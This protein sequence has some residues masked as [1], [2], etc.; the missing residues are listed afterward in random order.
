M[1]HNIDLIIDAFDLQTGQPDSAQEIIRWP[2]V[3]YDPDKKEVGL[4]NKLL[5][6]LSPVTSM[7]PDVVPEVVS[8]FVKRA[9]PK[10]MRDWIKDY[11]FGS[12]IDIVEAFVSGRIG[13]KQYYKVMHR[14]DAQNFSL[15]PN[16]SA[17]AMFRLKFDGGYNVIPLSSA[18]EILPPLVN[19]VVDVQTHSK[20]L[21]SLTKCFP[22][23]GMHKLLEWLPAS[24]KITHTTADSRY[25]E[26]ISTVDVQ[27]VYLMLQR[28]YT[29]LQKV[30]SKYGHTT[31]PLDINTL[32]IPT[33][34]NLEPLNK[35]G[36]NYLYLRNKK[37]VFCPKNAQQIFKWIDIDGDGQTDIFCD[38][39]QRYSALF[40]TGTGLKELVP[41]L[42][43]GKLSVEAQDG[44]HELN[45]W[46]SD[47]D[48]KFQWIDFNGDGRKDPACSKS[49]GTQQVL[50][51]TENGFK[52]PNNN[53]DGDLISKG[54]KPCTKEQSAL[55]VQWGDFNGDGK[56]DLICPLNGRY[57]VLL[58]NGSALTKIDDRT[59]LVKWRSLE[60]EV[61]KTKEEVKILE[62]WC[63]KEGSPVGSPL[64]L[65]VNGDYKIDMVCNSEDGI[66]YTLISYETFFIKG[67]EFRLS[68]YNNEEV[69][70]MNRWC[71]GQINFSDFNGDGTLDWICNNG[72]EQRVLLSDGKVLS[73][74]PSYCSETP[75]KGPHLPHECSKN[76]RW[77]DV[78]GDSKSDLVCEGK[79][80]VYIWLS[81]G[82][83]L[84]QINA[85][86][87]MVYF[88]SNKSPWCTGEKET[89]ELI[90]FNGDGILDFVCSG[91]DGTHRVLVGQYRL[92][93]VPKQNVNHDEL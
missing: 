37:A 89:R 52:S 20:E 26:S 6:V 50:L 65:D 12:V 80:G 30:A 22:D 11:T 64:F 90:D 85:D 88:N 45:S 73:F 68:L 24:Y 7:I 75:L 21:S 54:P 78:N 38:A 51:S 60:K 55:G 61:K 39:G 43:V 53:L 44:K 49:D 86:G 5:N 41:T 67:G 16:L 47:Q 14:L 28:L 63:V 17:Q 70:N 31:V 72:I 56:D 2:I 40:S 8:D 87:A 48:A 84:N 74:L 29:T 15:H 1:G 36:A 27:T 32:K 10:V 9:L 4:I 93:N 69:F 59:W 66:Q 35:D 58:S 83:L 33:R 23:A 62:N 18:V 34:F 46:C 57:Y 25:I 19:F 71:K 82:Q 81:N 42:P 76:A 79:T 3:T 77:I 13:F 91:G 92:D